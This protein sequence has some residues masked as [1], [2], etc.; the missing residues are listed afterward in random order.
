MPLIKRAVFILSIF[1]GLSLVTAAV[2]AG[3]SLVTDRPAKE[4]FLGPSDEPYAPTR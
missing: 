4:M 3:Y 1:V 2:F